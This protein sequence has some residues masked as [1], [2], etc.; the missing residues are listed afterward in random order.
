MYFQVPGLP[1]CSHCHGHVGI[2]RTGPEGQWLW[3][4]M[5]KGDDCARRPDNGSMT[6]GRPLT[7]GMAS[8]H[9]AEEAWKVEAEK[10][11]LLELDRQRV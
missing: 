7:N 9:L 4:V 3:F 8:Q 5:C 2:E 10:R 6:A 11:R 1:N